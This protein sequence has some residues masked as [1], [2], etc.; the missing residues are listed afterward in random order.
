MVGADVV[1]EPRLELDFVGEAAAEA[2]DSDSL[3]YSDE[4]DL[5]RIDPGGAVNEDGEIA[6]AELGYRI[7]VNCRP[8]VTPPESETARP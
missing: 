6:G 5:E 1:P 2:G 4:R 3:A 7:D 8:A